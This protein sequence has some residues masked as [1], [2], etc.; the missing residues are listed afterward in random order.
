MPGFMQQ[1]ISS[2]IG[3]RLTLAIILFS[4]LITL[5]TTGLQLVSDYKGDI[6]R[7]N[8]EFANIEKANLDVLAASIWVI[9]ERLIKTQLNGLNQLPDT[10]YVVIEDD[11]GKEWTAGEYRD[12]G[13]IEKRFPLV[14]K[15]SSQNFNVGELRVQADLSKIYDRLVNKALLILLANGIKTFLVAG[16]ILY[17]VWATITRHL[18]QLSEYCSEL[19][20]E[21]DYQP[22]QFKRRDKQDE[23][24][25]VALAINLMQQ[26]LRASFTQ[27]NRSRYE[28]QEAL[29]DRER[30]LEL[31]RSYKD[32]LARQVKE[33]TKELEQSLLVLERAQQVMV[34]QQKMAA[35]GGLVSGIAHEI[36]TPIG[37]CLTAA[38]SQLQHI[39]ELVELLQNDGATLEELNAILNEYQQ[40]CELI[41]SNITRA[42]NLIQKFKAI[43]AEQGNDVHEQMLLPLVLQEFADAVALS[44]KQ[45]QVD[46]EIQ[47]EAD[48]WLTS[49]HSL[50]KQIVTNILSNAYAHAFEGDTGHKISISAQQQGQEL[51]LDIEDNG[52][53]IAPE[54]AGQIFEPFFTTSRRTGATG[55]GLAAAFNAVTLLKGNITLLNDSNLGGAHFRVRFPAVIESRPA[56][57]DRVELFI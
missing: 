49:S 57:D 11:S 18:L 12:Q 10:S 39:N 25:Q 34:E 43:A 7:I 51:Q 31:E 55:L 20:L 28:L 17:L 36:N 24:T 21:Q 45:F 54:I 19:D 13:V 16:F 3:R 37:I 52:K 38:S 15:T 22:L 26:Q 56:D 8:D 23:F 53:G 40:S 41:I 9:D 42:S 48:L 1:L 44:F 29:S 27:L 50:L 6:G 4:S 5:V 47:V 2:P 46:V 14:H 35:L 33:Q 30:L 32:E